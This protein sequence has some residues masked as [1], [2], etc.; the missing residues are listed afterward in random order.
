MR[1]PSDLPGQ[2][3]QQL[4]FLREMG[5]DALNLTRKLAGPAPEAVPAG[6]DPGRALESL[7][8]EEIGDCRRCKLCEKRNTIV[9]GTGDPRARLMFVGE[10]P[11]HD[12]DLQG[13]PFVGRA[14]QLLNQI[15]QAMG[16]RREQVYIANV[17]KC[18]PPDNR[19]PQ[20]DETAACTPFLF[21]QIEI[22]RPAVIVALGAPAAQALLESSAGITKIRG[23]FRSFGDIPVMP[24]FHPAYLL[25][26][27]AAKRDVWED[28]KKVM[29]LLKG[30]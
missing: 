13:L 3:R 25:R 4:Q 2:V 23:T 7:R 8:V 20:P 28:M 24:T 21:R 26:N 6:E 30:E 17:V 27:P 12:E 18:R 1:G 16:L 10:G 9:F 15:I 11:G 22:I 14:G 19:T 29:A 5:V